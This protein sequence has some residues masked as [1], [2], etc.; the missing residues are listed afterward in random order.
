[1]KTTNLKK[2][3]FFLAIVA[4]LAANL[5]GI[6]ALGKED[7]DITASSYAERDPSGLLVGY[8][9]ELNRIKIGEH[10]VYDYGWV[11]AP[12]GRLVTDYRDEMCCRKTLRA[13]DG[14][15]DFKICAN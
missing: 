5:A 12:F 9:P 7:G 3:G 14:C 6:N 13:M 1:M 8:R 2:L 11:G 4:I 15:M 10:I